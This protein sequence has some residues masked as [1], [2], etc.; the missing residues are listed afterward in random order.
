MSQ[1][2]ASMLVG[3]SRSTVQYRATR[4]D[5]TALRQRLK[6]LAHKYRR[7]GSPMLH[8]VLRRERLVLNHK[9]TERIYREERLSLRTK[10]R[11]KRTAIRIQ[12]PPATAPNQVWA[13]DFIFDCLAN[14]RRI[15]IFSLIDEFSKECLALEVDTSI[16]GV[17]VAQILEAVAMSRVYPVSIRSDNGPE[18]TGKALY[19]WVNDR[20]NHIFI[21]PGRPTQNP[22]VESF[23]DKLRDELLEEHW[24]GT[25][26]EARERIADWKSGYNDFRPHSSL[27]GLTPNAFA[28]SILKEQIPIDQKLVTQK[29]LMA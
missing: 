27:N 14:G 4:Q 19:N 7:W 6:E 24:F 28:Q 18:F 9:R 20:I 12:M 29:A 23:H 26:K 15:K 5:D 22:F 8:M 21:E 10:R 16:S 3:L 1:R 25:L 13:M 11:K 17:R 2:R